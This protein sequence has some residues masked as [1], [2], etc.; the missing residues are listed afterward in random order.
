MATEI[1]ALVVTAGGLNLLANYGVRAITKVSQPLQGVLVATVSNIVF[2]VLSHKVNKTIISGSYL[3]KE[4]LKQKLF[5]FAGTVFGIAAS[6]VLFSK[7]TRYKTGVITHCAYAAMPALC[8]PL[9][10][11]GLDCIKGKSLSNAASNSVSLYRDTWTYLQ[12][13]GAKETFK[14]FLIAAAVATPLTLL[15]NW[16][17]RAKAKV[18]PPIMGALVAAISSAVFTVFGASVVSWKE[19]EEEPEW[20]VKTTII[21]AIGTLATTALFSAASETYKTGLKTNLAYVSLSTLLV[22]SLHRSAVGI[23]T[24]SKR[25]CYENMKHGF[26]ENWGNIRKYATEWLSPQADD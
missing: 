18:A 26:K 3:D 23:I 12:T 1:G 16:A 21:A 13:D 4:V 17:I 2:S 25:S 14:E 5:G 19:I 10:S 7:V 20:V 8:F 24:Y 15:A 9:A 22:P 6:S 11:F